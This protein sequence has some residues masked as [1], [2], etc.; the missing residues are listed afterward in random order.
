MVRD[1]EAYP[2]LSG[3]AHRLIPGSS[4]K[5]G[6]Q[7]TARVLGLPERSPDPWV[8]C[9]ACPDLR[10][11]VFDN[12]QPSQNCVEVFVL[13]IDEET[14]AGDQPRHAAALWVLHLQRL[15]RY[16]SVRDGQNEMLVLQFGFDSVRIRSTLSRKT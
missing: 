2:N 16:C 7:A 9:G 5:E 10:C 3:L 14:L 13:L 1:L 8:D 11:A 6:H 15:R 12:S 4:E